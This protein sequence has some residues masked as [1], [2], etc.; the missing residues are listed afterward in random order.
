[1]QLTGS[2]LL[3]AAIIFIRLVVVLLLST[4]VRHRRAGPAQLQLQQ[5]QPQ[6]VPHLQV[7][8]SQP[9][10]SVAASKPPALALVVGAARTVVLTLLVAA[11]STSGYIPQ[12]LHPLPQ[13]QL[14]PHPH[15]P[16]QQD[17]MITGEGR[18]CGSCL[19]CCLVAFACDERMAGWGEGYK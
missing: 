19:C 11:V 12:P 4:L 6:L 7:L 2:Y 1:M 5:E 17:D 3:D 16:P 10:P 8:Q 14:E 18:R 15:L 9:P 13:E